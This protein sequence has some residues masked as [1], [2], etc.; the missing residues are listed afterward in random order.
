MKLELDTLWDGL[1]NQNASTLQTMAEL[2]TSI[3]ERS[4]QMNEQAIRALS[5]PTRCPSSYEYFADLNLCW[6]LE[7]TKTMNFL[8][9][10][11]QCF[12]E[13]GHLI[14]LDSMA[15]IRFMH[16]YLIFKAPTV[17][18]VY[19]G[20]TDVMEEGKFTWINGKPVGTV[21]WCSGEPSAGSGEQC[22]VME[23]NNNYDFFD[24]GCNLQYYFLCQ[25]SL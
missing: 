4:L 16:Y 14:I 17:F 12:T 10:S 3:N 23:A 9:A 2:E 8:T 24:R 21:P 25:I 6:R 22:V 7:K 5:K 1:D 15:K 20:A 11:W 13:G 19:V 18:T